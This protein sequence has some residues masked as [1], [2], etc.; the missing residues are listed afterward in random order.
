MVRSMMD[1]V[2]SSRHTGRGLLA[3]GILVIVFLRFL[4]PQTLEPELGIPFRYQ[5]ERF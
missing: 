1:F 4:L 5:G 3:E 2:W